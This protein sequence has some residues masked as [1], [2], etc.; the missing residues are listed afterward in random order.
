[1]LNVGKQSQFLLGYLPGPGRDPC[2]P[3][4]RSP[5]SQTEAL[6]RAGP[7]SL[8]CWLE[9]EECEGGRKDQLCSASLASCRRHLSSVSSAAQQL[10]TN[11]LLVEPAGATLR[12]CRAQQGA[13]LCTLPLHTIHSTT[14]IGT[15]LPG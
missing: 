15:G 10:S 14:I 11:Q 2:S 8:Q 1:M 7:G 5:S 3:L 12:D 6:G 4:L 13:L 9:Y